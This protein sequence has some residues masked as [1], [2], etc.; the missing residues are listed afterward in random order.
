MYRFNFWDLQKNRT[1]E[2]RPWRRHFLATQWPDRSFI[3]QWNKPIHYRI[4]SGHSPKIPLLSN[5]DN[6]NISCIKTTKRVNAVMN[7]RVRMDTTWSPITTPRPVNFPRLYHTS[8]RTDQRD[9]GVVAL[10]TAAWVIVYPKTRG[11][12][13]WP[14]GAGVLEWEGR[15]YYSNETSILHPTADIE[16]TIFL[17]ASVDQWQLIAWNYSVCGFA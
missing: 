17:R 3:K 7:V 16:W 15:I 4:P 5:Q 13:R 10:L 6:K 1:K 9:G 12:A 8:T 11:P 2:V 14:R